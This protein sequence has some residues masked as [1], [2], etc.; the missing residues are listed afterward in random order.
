MTHKASGND[1]SFTLILKQILLL[2]KLMSLGK[3]TQSHN[4]DLK[5]FLQ[6]STSRKAR[7]MAEYNLFI[8]QQ[9]KK[10]EQHM[11]NV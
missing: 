1:S 6:G 8:I 3:L 10:L 5:Q 4:A 11:I 7:N 2:T 9:D